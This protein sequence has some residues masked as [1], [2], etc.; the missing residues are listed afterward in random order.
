MFKLLASIDNDVSLA[1]QKFARRTIPQGLSQ[2]HRT[3]NSPSRDKKDLEKLAAQHTIQ[4]AWKL[5]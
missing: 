2:K 3:G 5:G 4:S 1:V